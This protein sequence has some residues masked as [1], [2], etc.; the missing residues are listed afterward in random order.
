MLLPH[1]DTKLFFARLV[2]RLCGG[3]GTAAAAV[4]GLAAASFRQKI[5]VLLDTLVPACRYDKV[6]VCVLLPVDVLLALLR[7][8]LQRTDYVLCVV[9]FGVVPRRGSALETLD[10]Q[11]WLELRRVA[12]QGGLG[13]VLGQFA[14]D[15]LLLFPAVEMMMIG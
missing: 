1:I 7:G 11:S 3:W 12:W 13:V 15:D 8:T 2:I 9:A 4:A 10:R 14:S 6:C 5:D